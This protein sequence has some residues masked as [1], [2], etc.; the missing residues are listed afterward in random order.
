MLTCLRSVKEARSDG[1]VESPKASPTSEESLS[2][3]PHQ[4]E[5]NPIQSWV[6][7]LIARSQLNTPRL[8]SAQNASIRGSSYTFGS[9]EIPD[10]E[11]PAFIERLQLACLSQGYLA[12]RDRSI[13]IDRLRRP[14]RLLLS[15]MSRERI[16]S[17][18]EAALQSRLGQ[19]RLD[20][21]KDVPFFSLG[22][23]GAHYSRT[24]QESSSAGQ[25]SLSEQWVTVQDPLAQ[26]PPEVQEELN[27]DWFTLQDLEIFLRQKGVHKLACAPVKSRPSSPT[28]AAIN[29][30]RLIHGNAGF[31]H[32][33]YSALT[34]C[35]GLISRC[36]CLGRSPG[37]RRS[38]V[39]K[40]L[41]A[42]VLT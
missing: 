9:T 33:L 17:Y 12:L 24:P 21:W 13:S 39:E 34:S 25:L 28:R 2:S 41:S 35:L 5:I 18:F 4:G 40:A 3:P 11:L 30:A 32:F 27:G 6:V 16:T 31:L 20:G 1:E 8:S 29:V 26:F 37:F 10:I 23:A 14:F 19:Q 36:I 15:F 7:E 38:D 42:A 22:G